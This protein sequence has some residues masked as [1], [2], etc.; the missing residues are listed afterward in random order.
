MNSKQREIIDHIMLKFFLLN[1]EDKKT[2]NRIYQERNGKVELSNKDNTNL[3]EIYERY[4][5]Q[6]KITMEQNAS[7]WSVLI[8]NFLSECL[9][10]NKT[11]TIPNLT[12]WLGRNYTYPTLIISK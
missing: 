5:S 6:I 9:K 8:E 1:N 4:N 10:N 12:Q 2:I 3:S 7:K 11:A